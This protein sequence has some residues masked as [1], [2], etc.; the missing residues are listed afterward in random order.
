MR[1]LSTH[2][3]QIRTW[4]LRLLE[5]GAV[6]G[7]AQFLNAVSGLLIVHALAKTEYAL[8]AIANSMLTACHLLA[9]LGVG[10]GLKS[11]GGRFW[12]DPQRLGALVRTGIELRWRFAAASFAVCIPALAWLLW[13]NN[14]PWWV[15]AALCAV[16]AAGAIPLL[17]VSALTVVAQLVGD[18]RGLQQLDAGSAAMRLILI[19]VLALSWVNAVLA[20]LVG[21]VVNW[22][23][24]LVLRGRV[25]G[26]ANRAVAPN[27][28][29]RR[30]LI[31]LSLK[32]LPNAIFFC[33]QGQVTVII[34]TLLGTTAE[35][36][37]VTALGRLAALFGIFS[38]TFAAVIAPRFAR[39]QDVDRLAQL[40]RLLLGLS[41]LVLVPLALASWVFPR[42]FLWLLGEKYAGLESECG[43]VVTTGCIGQIL[44]VMWALNTSKAWIRFQSIGFI[45]VILLAQ[46]VAAVLLDLRQF[47]DVLIFAMVT[48]S[49][50]FPLYV[51]D[52][53][54]GLRRMRKERDAT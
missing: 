19:G 14:A 46:C 6:Q 39:T 47:R 37:D 20:A 21:M 18:Y 38:A 5:F 41:V 11:L 25:R 12:N 10:V 44:G 42:P 49:A 33:I 4:A 40:Y 35:I 26:H 29:D 16:V 43:W 45:P 32:S 7:I 13:A 2:A 1:W 31:A 3:Q 8:Y 24:L 27:A 48:A 34:L 28:E 15:I 17:T 52:A 23:Q 36:A 53:L 9:D 51:A 22:L 50:P 54:A 30:E